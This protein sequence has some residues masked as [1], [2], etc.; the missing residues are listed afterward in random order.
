MEKLWKV[1]NFNFITE[2]EYNAGI[3]DLQ[4][5]KRCMGLYNLNTPE[6]AS[7]MYEALRLRPDFFETVIGEQFLHKLVTIV[8][9]ADV[10]KQRKLLDHNREYAEVLQFIQNDA[11]PFQERYKE[12]LSLNDTDD[13]QTVK[14][15]KKKGLFPILKG[16]VRGF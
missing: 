13:L 5:I 11:V 16:F 1:G 12:V 14:Q 4:R 9:T 6:N 15:Q 3:R 8:V 10:D 2:E 7:T